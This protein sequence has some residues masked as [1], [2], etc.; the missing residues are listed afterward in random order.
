M[1][2]PRV[3]AC[4]IALLGCVAS[5]AAPVPKAAP[6]AAGILVLDNCDPDFKGKAEY[7]DN[8]TLLDGSGKEVFR[9]SGFNN[10]ETI[11]SAHVAAADPARKC[12]WVIENVAHRVRRFDL[13]T[14]K[15]TLAIEKVNGHAVAVDP[16]TGN[17]WV[18]NGMGL[19]NEGRTEV[20]DGE[21][22]RVASYDLPC[23]DLAYDPKAKAFWVVAKKLTKITA[24]GEVV[25]SADVSTWCAT[26]VEVDPKTG[27]GWVGVRRH[28]QV[29]G[30][31]NEL[32][33]FDADG[34]ER[35]RLDLGDSS[36]FRVS[37][38][39]ADGGA[40][41]AQFRKAVERFTPDGK[42]EVSHAVEALAAQT[43]PDGRG[44]WVVTPT[45]TQ[46]LDAKG[47]VKARAKHAGKTSQA[48]IAAVK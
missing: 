7:A 8:L 43:D 3:A 1:S 37:V 24:K 26:S 28:P 17:V 11:G 16:D 15:E 19:I 21:G 48:W 27:A 42:K 6:N 5:P 25:F 10:C 13:T 2:R 14:G 39:P 46:L 22:K 29:N 33:R 34:K 44:V 40:W 38:D 32:L 18:S 20:Y 45:E 23:Y 9:V 30:S 47:E 36:P 41:V 31:A 35:V 12:V 4:V